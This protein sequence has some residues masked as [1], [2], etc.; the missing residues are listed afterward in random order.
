[1]LAVSW[2]LEK[3]AITLSWLFSD[4]ISTAV[5]ALDVNMS[6]A[7]VLLGPPGLAG[8]PGPTGP[9][10]DDPGEA[11]VLLFNNGLI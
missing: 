4:S 1:M 2:R 5:A 6:R 9:I 8:P 7:L 11:F 10:G 3:P